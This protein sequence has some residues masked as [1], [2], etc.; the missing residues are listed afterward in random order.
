MHFS[1]DCTKRNKVHFTTQC[2]SGQD[3]QHLCVTHIKLNQNEKEVEMHIYD[4][5]KNIYDILK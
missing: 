4:N 5:V 3:V 1:A 2:E